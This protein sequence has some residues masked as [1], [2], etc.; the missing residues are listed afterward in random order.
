MHRHKRQAAMQENMQ[1]PYRKTQSEI[2]LGAFLNHAA[3]K[4]SHSDVFQWLCSEGDER[5]D[6]GPE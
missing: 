3:L 5:G 2:K 1:T 6:I 4:F